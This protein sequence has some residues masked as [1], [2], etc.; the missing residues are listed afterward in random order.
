MTKPATAAELRNLLKAVMKQYE[1][2]FC[3]VVAMIE[4]LKQHG[5]PIDEGLDQLA[6]SDKIRSLVHPSFEPLLSAIESE[7][8]EELRKALLKM[9][10]P[11]WKM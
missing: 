7:D 4:T 10:M 9:P 6:R 8:A 5:I 11:Q 3:T 1:N 2:A